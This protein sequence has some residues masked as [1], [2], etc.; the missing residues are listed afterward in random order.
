M[1]VK[2][3]ATPGNNWA[4]EI[5]QLSILVLHNFGFWLLL[6]STKYYLPQRSANL[7]HPVNC[8]K[9]D[10]KSRKRDKLLPPAIA[11]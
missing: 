6:V 8:Y 1:T 11:K 3:S 4:R 7:F 5:R 9:K 2:M 10:S